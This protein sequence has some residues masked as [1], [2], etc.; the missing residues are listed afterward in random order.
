M[1]TI[2]FCR[3]TNGASHRV[4][5]RVVGTK[6]VSNCCGLIADHNGNEIWKYKG[7]NPNPYRQEHADLI[8]AI[9]GG[10]PLNEAKRIAESTM[11]AVIGR[12]SAYTGRAFK[13]DWA[14][15]ASKLDLM[16]KDLKF[17]PKPVAPVSKPGS[18]PLI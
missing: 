12:M 10:K 3:Q 1:R 11:T 17:G 6:G 8:A 13:W 4:G 14:M 7:P 15:K 9:R 5:E 16:P 2:S 18:T